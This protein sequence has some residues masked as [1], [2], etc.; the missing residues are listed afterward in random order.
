M[1]VRRSSYFCLKLL[2][3]GT[4]SKMSAVKPLQTVPISEK[5]VIITGAN[6]GI[7]AGIAIHLAKVGYKKLALLARRKEKLDEVAEK[8]RKIGVTDV[9][10]L[11]K[12]LLVENS[13]LEAIKEA[14]EHFGSEIFTVVRPS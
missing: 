12:D 5:V 11:A 7:G 8:C 4:T 13:S 14:V 3:R 1:R 9:L 2:T 6:S 10:V